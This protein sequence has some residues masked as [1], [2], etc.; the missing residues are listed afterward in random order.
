MR[1]ISMSVAQ[2]IKKYFSS[3]NNLLNASFQSHP[4]KMGCCNTIT[5][6]L[7]VATINP[8]WCSHPVQHGTK[9]LVLI[10]L[11]SKETKD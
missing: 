2:T 5:K 11:K 8:I 9:F 7:I 6:C 4:I 1:H 10:S 3:C